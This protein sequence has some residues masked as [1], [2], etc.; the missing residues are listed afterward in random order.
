M[1]VEPK[2]K[3]DENDLQEEIMQ[4]LKKKTLAMIQKKAPIKVRKEDLQMVEPILA[5]YK[6]NIF[7]RMVRL[8]ET[9]V[10]MGR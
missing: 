9:P 1:R 3:K 5:L 4:K 10:N 6:V 2:E 7:G 8:N